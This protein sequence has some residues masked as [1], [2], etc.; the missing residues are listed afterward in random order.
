[1]NIEMGWGSVGKE[2]EKWNELEY[3]FTINVAHL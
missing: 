1:M 2:S 3:Q